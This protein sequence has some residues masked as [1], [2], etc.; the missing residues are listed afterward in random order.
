M[1]I[2]GTRK[3]SGQ[4]GD[5]VFALIFAAILGGAGGYL[6]AA[7]VW[8]DPA[9]VWGAVMGAGLMMLA[10][11]LIATRRRRGEPRRTGQRLLPDFFFG[12]ILGWLLGSLLPGAGPALQGLILGLASGLLGMGINKIILG[13][14]VGLALGLAG[15]FMLPALPTAVLGALVLP[16]IRIL[17]ALFIRDEE[18]V[19]LVGEQISKEQVRYVVPFEANSKYVGVDYMRDLARATDGSFRRNLPGIGLVEN[20]EVLRGPHFDPGRVDPLI[21]E[22][23]E[24]TS[25]FKLTIIPEWDLRYKPLFWAFK[26]FFAQP[27]GQANLPFNMEETQKGVV[28]YID[29]IDFDCDD[30]VDL[31]GWIRAYRDSQ[32]AI[33]VGIYTTMRHAE[34]GYVSVG[35]PLPAANFS[36]TLLPYNH[37]ESNFLLKTQETGMEFPGHYLTAMDKETGGLTVLKLPT[38]GEEI[39]VY[40]EDGE[41]RTEHRF[42]I[43]GLKFLSLYYTIERSDG[44]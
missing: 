28:S 12:G 13:A 9:R 17:S 43:A 31:R 37:N 20:V 39:E 21:R 42:Y 38:F 1:R 8:G 10:E 16:A 23:Y 14:V 44:T 34:V 29:T 5:V 27:I 41:L 25:N 30:I 2:Q 36:A 35:F 26:R 33:Y 19:R 3:R 15:Q 6:L 22:F 11:G 7:S 18:P 40:V 24:H 32:E 4:F